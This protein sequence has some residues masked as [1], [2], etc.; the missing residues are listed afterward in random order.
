VFVASLP[1]PSSFHGNARW[2]VQMRH[3]A[4]VFGAFLLSAAILVGVVS[5]SAES[6]GTALATFALIGDLGY[7][8][9]QEPWFVN[10]MEDLNGEPLE[11][12]VHDGDLWGGTFCTDENYRARL[13][14]FNSSVHPLVYTPGD[15]EWTDCHQRARGELDP[16]ERL[17]RLRQ[18]FFPDE[19]SLGQRKMQLTRQS[20]VMPAFSAY[21]ENALW[22]FADVTFATVHIVG[23]NNNLGR[24]LENDQEH[25]ARNAAN[26][27]WLRHVFGQARASSSR[28]VMIVQQANPFFERPRDR[29]VAFNDVLDVLEEETVAF[30]K[31]V[32]LI[33]G[34]TH[35]F[36]IDKP[37]VS[38]ASGRRIENFTRLETFGQ[39]DHHWVQVF[40]EPNDPNLFAFR[41]RLVAANLVQ[42]R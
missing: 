10:V 4:R 11:F 37:L 42:H 21:R 29:R 34:D 3:A 24:T 17:P 31:P 7:E 9:E 32:V 13:A 36:R 23:S 6:Q 15:N 27:A 41:Q 14:L 35:Y 8:E 2:R 1:L 38:R 12:V 18:I 25:Q 33:H 28:G 20:S 39:P 30:G 26:L 22:S 40:I 19:S 16:L 5:R